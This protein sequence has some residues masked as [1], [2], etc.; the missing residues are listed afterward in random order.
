MAEQGAAFSN[1][2]VETRFTGAAELVEP[3]EGIEEAQ[4]YNGVVTTVIFGRLHSEGND[5]VPENASLRFRYYSPEGIPDSHSAH[6]LDPARTGTFMLKYYARPD[7]ERPGN[8]KYNIANIPFGDVFRPLE[9]PTFLDTLAAYDGGRMC[10]L[11]QEYYGTDIIMPLIMV[12]AQRRHLWVPEDEAGIGPA[13]ITFD[14]NT[15]FWPVVERKPGDVVVACK[16]YTFDQNILEVKGAKPLDPAGHASRILLRRLFGE[17]AEGYIPHGRIK[18]E[19]GR[20]AIAL[21]GTP[22]LHNLEL[23]HIGDPSRPGEVFR[24]FK[25]RERKIDTAADPRDATRAISTRPREG[26]WVDPGFVAPTVKFRFHTFNA[27][28]GDTIVAVEKHRYV[29]GQLKGSHFQHKQLIRSGGASADVLVR[30]E[31]MAPTLPDLWNKIGQEPGERIG[32]TPYAH[33]NRYQRRVVCEDTGNVFVILA[34][35][36][37]AESEDGGAELFQVEIEFLGREGFDGASASALDEEL[38]DADFKR[39]EEVVLEAPDLMATGGQTTKQDWLTGRAR[40]EA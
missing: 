3:L 1:L 26:I 4:V 6:V 36:C 30:H 2:R 31:V 9:S 22:R 29:D 16:A 19:L 40:Q 20:R 32:L 17:A 13:R 8:Q 37:R 18:R 39:I 14:R 38:I 34:D 7:E 15:T 11:I 33:R 25:E 24:S 10:D 28:G 21:G 23:E 12:Q 35:Y 5:K 27:K